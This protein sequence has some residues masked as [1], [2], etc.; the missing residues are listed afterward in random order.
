MLRP[1]ERER[2]RERFAREKSWGE[3]QLKGWVILFKK[4]RFFSVIFIL[5]IGANFDQI[6]KNTFSK[7]VVLHFR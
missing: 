6:A 7:I 2:E 4:K 3:G 1:K 5:P